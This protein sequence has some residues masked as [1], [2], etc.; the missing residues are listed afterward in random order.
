MS[1]LTDLDLPALNVP[2]EGKEEYDNIWQKVRSIWLLVYQRHYEEFD[3]FYIGGDDLYVVVENLRV[4]LHS[5]NITDA[6]T[7]LPNKEEK[8]G[9]SGGVGVGG[10][11]HQRPLF[12]GRRFA[13]GG[14]PNTM[15]NSGGAGYL[16]NKASLKLLASNALDNPLCQPHLHGF[17]EDVQVASCLKKTAGVLPFD[18]RDYQ[19]RERFHPFTPGSHLTYRISPKNPDWYAKYSVELKEGLDCCSDASVAFHYVK[20]TLMLK[21]HALLYDCRR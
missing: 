4:F 17:W 20:E 3:W 1:D 21:L 12:L 18:T 8:G 11:P 9:I 15:F 2:H 16:L 10:L 14:N 7:S 13:Q 19:G 5:R 6:A